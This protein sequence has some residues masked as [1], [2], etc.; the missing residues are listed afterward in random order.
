MILVRI[1]VMI[2]GVSVTGVESVTDEFRLV[3]V[4][5]SEVGSMDLIGSVLNRQGGFYFRRFC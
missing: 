4:C 3:L 1:G 2:G 5:V